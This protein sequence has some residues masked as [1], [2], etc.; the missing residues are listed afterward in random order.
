[1]T[2]E[3]RHAII[4]DNLLRHER[5]QVSELADILEVSAV[6]I[7]KDLTELEKA[8]KLYRSH[9]HAIKMDPYIN[10]RSVNEKEK[11]MPK[12]KLLIGAKAASLITRDDSIIVASGTT[13][14]AFARCIK[15]IHRLTVMS[16]SLAVS[17][18]LAAND[19]IEII[20]LGGIL[21]HSSQSVVGEYAKAPFADCACSKLFLGVDGIDL[22]YG[23]TTTDI[24]EAE[25]NKTMI[26]AAQKVI[27]LAD[28]SK[29]HRRGFSKIAEI[30]EVDLVI[31]DSGI[32]ASTAR[33]LEESGIE[34]LIAD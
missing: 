32:P 31:T 16:A 1:M 13:I 26:Q 18:M 15:P 22:D 5:V 12:E 33:R 20:Q 2:K 4:L 9:G 29:F 14:H 23:I 3:E 27:V 34:L 19:A 28:S 21:R 6:T 11:L 10:N 24:R 25:L 17:E 7:R 8:G 30:D